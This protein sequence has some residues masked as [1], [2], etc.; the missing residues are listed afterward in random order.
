MGPAP[1]GLPLG[2]SGWRKP[3]QALQTESQGTC[4]QAG[5]WGR[6]LTSS[7][8]TCG[9][10]A[11]LECLI[12][13]G[14]LQGSKKVPGGRRGEGNTQEEIHKK[15]GSWPKKKIL[16]KR[17]SE[18]HGCEA[19]VHTWDKDKGLGFLGFLLRSGGFHLGEKW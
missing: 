3:P 14:R 8:P 1:A 7:A 11:E 15:V 12:Y 19:G 16:R 5:G 17:C 6:A 2:N 13:T 9:C 4:L 10:L 18:K